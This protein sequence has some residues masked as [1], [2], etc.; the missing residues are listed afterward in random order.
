MMRLGLH[1]WQMGRDEDLD[2]MVGICA[3]SGMASFE[4]MESDEFKSSVP[5]DASSDERSRIRTLFDGAGVEIAGLS[6]VCAYDSM[7]PGE[8]RANIEKTKEYIQLAAD[9]RA[10]RLRCLGDRLH[11]DEGEAK[12]V[13]ID[14][15]AGA[16]R[17][18]C[19]YA[20]PFGVDCPIEMHNKFSPWENSLA[21]VEKVNH[22]R[23]YLVHNGT[24]QNTPPDDWD[25]VWKR[26]QPHVRHVHVH[27]IISDAFPCKRFFLTLRDS[28]YDGLVSLELAQSDDP[29]RVLK[30]T[31]A[32][33][34]EWLES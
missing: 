18:L 6:I 10:P 1:G 16:L 14:R 12:E 31:K 3:E 9:I 26:I 33:V 30:L 2:T 17:E 24:P 22:E 15:V 13:T 19:E 23:C 5:L 27:D 20:E 21:V 29:V 32:L 7:D 25:A 11:E 28:G 4:I 34:D 8:V